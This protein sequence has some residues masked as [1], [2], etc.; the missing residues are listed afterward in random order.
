[1][2]K[3]VP[4]RVLRLISRSEVGL[5]R[6]IALLVLSRRRCSGGSVRTVRAS[7]TLASI[8]FAR[9][10]AVFWYFAKAISVRRFASPGSGASRMVRMSRAASDRMD[11]FGMCANALRMRWNWQRCPLRPGN[12]CE[13]GLSRRAEP[14]CEERL[15]ERAPQPQDGRLGLAQGARYSQDAAFSVVA[16]A[17]GDEDRAVDDPFPKR[18]IRRG[19]PSRSV[20]RE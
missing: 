19:G 8:Q 7:A 15:E 1:L 6:S 3:R 16:D 20:R 2:G 17:D 14:A 4:T 18:A 9:L 13:D 12:A 10:G 5:T 11:C